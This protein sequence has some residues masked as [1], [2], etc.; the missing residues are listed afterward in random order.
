LLSLDSIELSLLSID[1]RLL[2]LKSPLH[3]L[4]LLFARLHLITDQGSADKTHRRADTRASAGVT[5]SGPN[6][7]AQTGATN[8]SEDGAF[9][10][11]RQ[12]LRAAEKNNGQGDS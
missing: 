5:G 10:S 11:R 2:R 1:F 7:S 4:F 9:L 6:D 12:R 8:G 3:V